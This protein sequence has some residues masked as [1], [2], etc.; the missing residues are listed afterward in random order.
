MPELGTTNTYQPICA[1]LVGTGVSKPRRE[2][3]S[4]ATLVPRPIGDTHGDGALCASAL[5]GDEW[6]EDG[7]GGALTRRA[8]MVFRFE[9]FRW[10]PSE[11]FNSWNWRKKE[12]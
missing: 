5:G 9:G 7:F 8:R 6:C 11:R 12:E 3:N 10:A 4:P 2:E 1:Q